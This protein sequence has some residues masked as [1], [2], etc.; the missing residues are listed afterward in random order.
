MRKS[1]KTQYWFA[2]GFLESGV[3]TVCYKIGWLMI[4]CVLYVDRYSYAHARLYACMRMSEVSI[5]S[6]L[7]WLSTLFSEMGSVMEPGA[8]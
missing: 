3:H 8:H 7:K 1:I 4:V 6:L 2:Q 5:K